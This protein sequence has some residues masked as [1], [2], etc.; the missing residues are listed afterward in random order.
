MNLLL[1]SSPVLNKNT[2]HRESLFFLQ[3]GREF[4]KLLFPFD[5]KQSLLSPLGKNTHPYPL[6][7]KLRDTDNEN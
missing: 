1:E 6:V 2:D 3:T 5:S 7:D 4:P